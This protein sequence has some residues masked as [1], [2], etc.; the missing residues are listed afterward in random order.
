MDSMLVSTVVDFGKELQNTGQCDLL[1]AV[2]VDFRSCQ[3]IKMEQRISAGG[4][5][6][7]GLTSQ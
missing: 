3:E 7:L 1:C 5:V 2:R 4:W 6:L